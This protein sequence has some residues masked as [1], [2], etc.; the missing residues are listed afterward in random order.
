MLNKDIQRKYIEYFKKRVSIMDKIYTKKVET[1]TD[2]DRILI[3]MIFMDMYML[4]RILKNIFIYGS[5]NIFIYCGELHKNNLTD[6]FS[7]FFDCNF[8]SAKT[9]GRVVMTDDLDIDLLDK[10]QSNVNVKKNKKNSNYFF[11]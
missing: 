11:I 6:F 5:R 7:V 4:G 8:I 2:S 9:D 1:S 3:F 10:N